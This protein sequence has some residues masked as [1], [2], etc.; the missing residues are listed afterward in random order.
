MIFIDC[1]STEYIPSLTGSE[2]FS[3]F[4]H[5]G[6]Y[7][8]HCMFHLVA[9]EVLEDLCY[10]RWL[11]TFGDKVHVRDSQADVLW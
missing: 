2:V 3:R 9:P 11:E 10:R 7:P 1:P 4:Q 5:G 6:E 8:I